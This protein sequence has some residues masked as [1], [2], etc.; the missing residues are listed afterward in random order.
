[1]NFAAFDALIFSAAP[2]AGYGRCGSLCLIPENLPEPAIVTS[3]PFFSVFVALQMR[4]LTGEMLFP[5][6]CF[7]RNGA[8]TT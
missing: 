3:W 8:Q 1:V 4:R 7:R 2:V 6:L 5:T